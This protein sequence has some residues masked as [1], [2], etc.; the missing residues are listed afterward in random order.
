MTSTSAG[1]ACGKCVHCGNTVYL[2]LAHG[3]STAVNLPPVPSAEGAQNSS[4]AS[5][6]SAPESYWL[7]E[8]GSPCEWWVRGTGRGDGTMIHEEWTTDSSKAQRFSQWGAEHHAKELESWGVKGPLRATDH[9][10]CNY[11]S[12]ADEPAATVRSPSR[13]PE[14]EAQVIKQSDLDHL[15]AIA[16][17]IGDEHYFIKLRKAYESECANIPDDFAKIFCGDCIEN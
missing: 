14:E 6:A 10:D 1:F 16:K 9:L 8:R 13:A 12:T 11:P 2:G 17:R 5:P 4:S 3:C 7:V 15:Q